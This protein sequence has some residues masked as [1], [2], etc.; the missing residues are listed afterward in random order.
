LQSNYILSVTDHLF[1]VLGRVSVFQ[2]AATWMKAFPYGAAVSN[3]AMK[4]TGLEMIKNIL[5]LVSAYYGLRK[6]TAE[7]QAASTKIE[8]GLKGQGK[9]EERKTFFNADQYTYTKTL[10]ITQLREAKNGQLALTPSEVESLQQKQGRFVTKYGTLSPLEVVDG[11]IT[12]KSLKQLEKK[13][14]NI[15]VVTPSEFVEQQIVRAKAKEAFG[16]LELAKASRG[17]N[18]EWLKATVISFACGIPF[19]I[20][21]NPVILGA[22]TTVLFVFGTYG[23]WCIRQDKKDEAVRKK[24]ENDGI[25]EIPFAAHLANTFKPQQAAASSS[26]PKES[27]SDPEV[28]AF[29]RLF[30]SDDD[31]GSFDL[32]GGSDNGHFDS[33]ESD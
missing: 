4:V 16:K 24:L 26:A 7:V 23:L 33:S 2:T 5:L 6:N 11:V 8:K 25:K 30:G 31:N 3:V 29:S 32:H 15:S 19:G 21:A 12:E 27:S 18:K 10:F 17:I 14:K 22:F 9:W 1:N 13:L 20:L 28:S